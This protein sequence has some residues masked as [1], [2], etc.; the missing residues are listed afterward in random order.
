VRRAKLLL[1]LLLIFLFTAV[2]IKPLFKAKYVN[3]WDSIESTYIADGRFLR[4]HAPHP[5]WQPLWYCGTRY[6]YIYPPVIRY[7]TALLAGIFIPAKAYHVWVGVLY[8]LGIAGIYFL[9]RTMSG[10]RKSGWLAAA[11]AALITPVALLVPKLRWSMPRLTPWSLW[12]LVRE[13]EG[14][15]VAAVAL[16]PFAL[17]FSY[18]ALRRNRPA[19]VAAAA[20]SCAT[21][22]LTNFYGSTGLGVLYPILVWSIWATSRDRYVWLRAAAIA[23]LAY[24][25]SAFWLTPSYLWLTIENLK[26]FSPPG[27]HSAQLLVLSTA[28]AFA[29]GSMLLRRRS[30]PCRYHVFLIGATMLL[31]VNVLGWDWLGIRALAEP[32]RLEVE[33]NVVLVLVL[34]ESVRQLWRW[35]ARPGM[36]ARLARALA[37][38]VV[39]GGAW[40]ARH[41]VGHAWDS[42]LYPLDPDYRQR[43]EYRMPAWIASHMPQAR[44]FATG[45]VRFWWNV[46]HDTPQVGGGCDRGVLNQ[47]L[48][49]AMFQVTWGTNPETAVRWLT[50][51]GVDALIVNDGRSQEM[52]HD[53]VHPYKF[54]GVLPVLY[55]DGQGNVIYKVPRRYPSLARVVDA[56]RLGAVAPGWAA[57]D[58]EALRRY[59]AVI[60]EGPDAP[61]TAEWKGTDAMRIHARV[62]RGRSIVVQETYDPAWHAY[63]GGKE[64]RVRPDPLSFMAIDAPPGEDDIA[65]VFE[66]PMENRIGWILLWLSLAIAAALFTYGPLRQRFR[67]QPASF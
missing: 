7:G 61:P 26:W 25:L 45:S 9:S 31:A 43:V 60:E 4:E 36:P 19:M 8:C 42:Y 13:G 52:Y 5:Q 14:P 17:A 48:M 34:V 51:L 10:S 24:G 59:T 38:I 32:N 41:Y 47:H 44:T 65:L 29:V 40:S 64:L 57:T 18:L 23:A 2:L 50:A 66:M 53:F 6:D 49:H 20:L 27:D 63:L 56:S 16:L 62:D 55:D 37:L 35:G 46:W 39:L 28:V 1:D 58:L 54:N 15:H 67:R 11:S 12:V 30:Q 22:A 33:F 21:V 3:R